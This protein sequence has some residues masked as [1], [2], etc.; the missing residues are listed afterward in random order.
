MQLAVVMP[1][2]SL[3]SAGQVQA[4]EMSEPLRD[5]L[6]FPA[7]SVFRSQRPAQST[8][9]GSARQYQ[10]VLHSL[11]PA[12]ARDNLSLQALQHH[13]ARPIP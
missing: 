12:A 8:V 13:E 6:P 9:R 5:L 11:H 3:Y 2:L 1:A 10:E 7:Q 4:T